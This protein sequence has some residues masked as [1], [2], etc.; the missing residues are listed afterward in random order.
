MTCTYTLEGIFESVPETKKLAV[1][2]PAGTFSK[3]EWIKFASDFCERVNAPEPSDAAEV[4]DDVK[5]PSMKLV[6]IL[7]REL[8]VWPD[9]EWASIGQ[10]NS[11]TLH[12]STNWAVECGWTREAYTMADDWTRAHVTYAEWQAAVDALNDPKVVDLEIDWSKQPE[13]FPLWLEG[14]NKDHRKHSGWYRSFGQIFE[15]ADGGQWRACREG[16]FFTVHRK[17]EPK[18]VEWD[19][20]GTPPDGVTVEIK[21]GN[22]SWIEG[23][24]WQIGKTATVMSSFTN[25]RGLVIASVQFP[26]G[27]CECI[28]TGCL[29]P[30]RISELEPVK[31]N[32]E[33]PEFLKSRI[34]SL[35]AELA[36]AHE[37]LKQEIVLEVCDNVIVGLGL[38]LQNRF[39]LSGGRRITLKRKGN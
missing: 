13:G 39:D 16:Q 37:K 33:C 25:S 6:D 1:D 15:G 11:G 27:H 26:G 9:P 21:R 18:V 35:E 20:V 2:R 3:A 29:S 12:K 36:Q 38:G 28:L 34:E 32:K 22:C 4:T 31:D 17:P 5:Y 14:A 7:A 23:D 19:G 8:K 24:E 10:S 30:S